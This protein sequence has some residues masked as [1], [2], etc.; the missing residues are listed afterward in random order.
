ML[1]LNVY[2]KFTW[3][4]FLAIILQ[5]RWTWGQLIRYPPPPELLYSRRF[6]VLRQTHDILNGVAP[7][8]PADTGTVFRSV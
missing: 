3:N 2:W 4:F 1:A 7:T 6:S 8:E 5:L